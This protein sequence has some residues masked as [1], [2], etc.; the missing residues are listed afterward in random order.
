MI[1]VRPAAERGYFDHG[2]LQTH[3][4]FSFAGY[5]DPAQM[6]FRALRVINEDWVAPGQGFGMHPHRDMEIVTW[7]LEGRLEHQDSLGHR[8]TIGVGEAQ[9][10]TAGRGI[11]HSEFNPSDDEAVH[12]LQ[13]WLLPGVRGRQPE[14]QQQPVPPQPGLTLLASPSG[15]C[16]SLTMH[17][18]NR[19]YVAALDGVLAAEL[20]LAPGRQA[21]VQVTRG[22]VTVN[23][24]VLTAGD[25]AALSDEEAVRLSST[26]PAEALVFDLG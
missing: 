19:L 26:A 23:G 25:G 17:T 8:G 6:G 12:L 20:P 7:V 16:G 13:I 18:D 21:W 11:L 10:I 15:E 4:S 22:A 5:Q 9:R 24:T 2:W 3:H 14:Y 1:T